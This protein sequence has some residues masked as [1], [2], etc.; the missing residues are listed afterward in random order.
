VHLSRADHGQ[1]G[2]CVGPE[3]DLPEGKR[4]NRGLPISAATDCPPTMNESCLN[5]GLYCAAF[6]TSA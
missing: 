3:A 6:W 2:S 4:C 5:S 1:T